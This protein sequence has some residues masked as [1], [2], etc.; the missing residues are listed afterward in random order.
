M[1]LNDLSDVA[2]IG[3]DFPPMKR[4]RLLDPAYVAAVVIVVGINAVNASDQRTQTAVQDSAEKWPI[5]LAQNT[6]PKEKGNKRTKLNVDSKG[7]ILKGYDA[8]A[9]IREGKPVK[10]APDITS[11]YQGATYLFASAEHKADF[12]KD[13]PKYAPQ[14]GGFCAYGIS[15]GVLADAEDSPE[16]FAVY[17]AKLYICGNEAALEKFSADIDRNIEKADRQ[18]RRI[19]EL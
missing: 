10:G 8:V 15:L 5:V 2:M 16:A 11:S 3:E 12:D 13:P 17:N 9:Y 4:L 19:S 18:W 7:V 6:V 1:R 14:Y